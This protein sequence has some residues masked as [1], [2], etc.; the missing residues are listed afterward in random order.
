MT[1]M[2]KHLRNAHQIVPAEEDVD[3]A[4]DDVPSAPT[5]LS[6]SSVATHGQGTMAWFLSR[7][8]NSDKWYTRLVM[9]DSL[10]FNQI[11]SCEF[12]SVAFGSLGLK[13]T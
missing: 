6:S 13:H 3:G 5:G 7:N 9:E 4:A 12:L 10:S 11:A 1:A 8:R 2:V